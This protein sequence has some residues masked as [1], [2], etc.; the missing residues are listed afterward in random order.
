MGREGKF[1]V[2][3]NNFA[4]PVPVEPGSLSQGT[5]MK[6][7]LA[8][9]HPHQGGARATDTVFISILAEQEPSRVKPIRS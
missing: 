4:C 7:S 5:G 1:Q 8:S 2:R 3:E 9:S 6:L